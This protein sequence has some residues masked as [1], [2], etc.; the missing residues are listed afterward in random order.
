MGGLVVEPFVSARFYSVV[1]DDHH[2]SVVPMTGLFD[3]SDEVAY[4]IVGVGETVFFFIA[5]TFEWHCPWLMAAECEHCCKPR[6]CGFRA[7]AYVI[8][9]TVKKMLTESGLPSRHLVIFPSA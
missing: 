7:T 8:C 9:E 2:K 1:G 6:L 3:A 5:E 4:A